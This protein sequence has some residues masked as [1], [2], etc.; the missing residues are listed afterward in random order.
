MKRNLQ[1]LLVILYL[2]I[3]AGNLKAN[4]TT[5]IHHFPYAGEVTDMLEDGNFLWLGT[6]DGLV[7]FNK[8]TEKAEFF[9][10]GQC[11]LLSLDITSLCK[12]S[13][14]NLWIRTLQGITKF[15]GEKWENYLNQNSSLPGGEGN[16]IT[17][18]KDGHIWIAD[19]YNLYDFYNGRAT[20]CNNDPP[21]PAN[22]YTRTMQT[23]GN[24]VLWLGS[25]TYGL[26][27]FEGKKWMR[28]DTSNSGIP[29]NMVNFIIIDRDGSKW[30]ATNKGIARL[31]DTIW[32]LWNTK[33]SSINQDSLFQ[34]TIDKHG[35]ICVQGSK[36]I[37]IFKDG[38]FT[39]LT[40]ETPDYSV[41]SM[42]RDSSDIFWMGTNYGLVK[43]D[44]KT[45]RT[46]KPSSIPDLAKNINA[47]A[48]DK[49]GTMW[50]GSQNKLIKYDGKNYQAFNYSNSIILSNENINSIQ[51]DSSGNIWILGYLAVYKYDGAN[52]NRF[53]TGNSLVSDGLKYMTVD[54]KGIVWLANGKSLLKYNGTGW[55]EFVP[56]KDFLKDDAFGDVAVDIDGSIWFIGWEG[57]IYK[58]K[59]SVWSLIEIKNYPDRMSYPLKLKI[60]AKGNKW[61]G[62]H[63]GLLKYDNEKLTF[64]T[65]PYD[66]SSR[67]DVLD[68]TFD[69]Q[70]N[71]WL[72]T[73]LGIAKIIDS[74][75]KLYGYIGLVY[76]WSSLIDCLAFDKGGN[77]W[78]SSRGHLNVIYNNYGDYP[79][80]F[81]KAVK[82]KYQLF[83]GKTFDYDGETDAFNGFEILPGENKRC[84]IRP[85]VTF[86]ND[87]KDQA[88]QFEVVATI[89]KDYENSLVFRKS[90][91][92]T[93]EALANP[94]SSGVQW[95]DEIGNPL[96][97][98]KDSTYKGLPPGGYARVSFDPFIPNEI[99]PIHH[100]RM[101][102]RA[103]SKNLSLP[104][105]TEFPYEDKLDDTLTRVV[106]SL[107]RI[108]SLHDECNEYVKSGSARLPSP[109]IWVNQGVEVVDGN[110]YCYQPM[111]AYQQ[112]GDF[113]HRSFT[114]KYA[115]VYLMNRKAGDAD[116][117]PG[118]RGG[119]TLTSHVI[120]M[121][122]RYYTTLSFTYQRTGKIGNFD[123]GWCDNSLVGPEHRVISPGD[124]LNAIR[125]PDELI[126]EYI[127]ENGTNIDRLL[128]PREEDWHILPRRGGAPPEKENPPLTI[129]GGG[130]RRVA[131]FEGDPDSILTRDNGLRA[132]V[133]D[134]GKDDYFKIA[135]IVIPDTVI[136]K[137]GFIRFRLRVNAE[138]NS[139]PGVLYDDS[140]NFYVDDI[141]ILFNCG[142]PDLSV[143]EIQLNTHYCINSLNTLNTITPYLTISNTHSNP[144][145]AFWVE[146]R[147]KLKNYPEWNDTTPFDQP[148]YYFSKQ[149][150][151]LLPFERRRI[152]LPFWNINGLS[153][154]LKP[155]KNVIQLWA[156]LV[157]PGGD[158]DQSNDTLYT[159][160]EIWFDKGMGY[161]NWENP[162]SD[163]GDFSYPGSGISLYGHS[164]GDDSVSNAVGDIGGSGPGQIAM[165]FEL[166]GKDTIF[167]FQAFFTQFATAPDPIRFAIY[168][169][170]DGKPGDLVEGSI[171]DRN[172]GFDDLRE[173]WYINEY[174]TYLYD[175]KNKPPVLEAGTY[176]AAIMQLGETG[177]Q[178]GA[179]GFRAGMVTT[180]YDSAGNGSRGTSLLIHKSLRK[181]DTASKHLLNDS[182]WYYENDIGSGNWVPFA[183]TVGNP[184]YSHLD[185]A[186]TIRNGSRSARTYSRGTFVPMLRVYMDGSHYKPSD[187]ENQVESSNEKIHA[188]PNPAVNFVV[189]DYVV[190]KPGLVDI[191]ISNMLGEDVKLLFNGYRAAG[192]YELPLSAKD[193][194]SG[195]YLLRLEQASGTATAKLM[196]VK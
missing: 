14:D 42:I 56:G 163:A 161:D 140:D 105:S 31:K 110:Q 2:A 64:F 36:G 195:M 183:P 166:P 84:G 6:L 8:L 142:C 130:G 5:Y 175:N 131:L 167:G 134:D 58:F 159:E 91:A 137:G 115:P 34:L 69:S 162:H 182:P 121:R 185:H 100:G 180:V 21:T 41:R 74:K 178:L 148:M 111:N 87:T 128:N 144:I 173:Q 19:D 50:M 196:I 55:D 95:V 83:N 151:Y 3:T 20:S 145:W 9:Y 75:V 30:L 122:Y 192:N 114:R 79:D 52:W 65:N 124:T 93:A 113:T 61:I 88:L 57:K 156:N 81:I 29:S 154:Y 67:F 22:L 177:L 90:K 86:K 107:N 76:R 47:I 13:S 118:V 12:D 48:F 141:R 53:D 174:S 96:Y 66:S 39:N 7:K 15:D 101:I 40:F 136:R 176:W 150:T 99:L 51:I 126:L 60:D 37:S 18:G 33:N 25:Y 4:D 116:V 127:I 38:T 59:D 191:T 108:E 77:L 10:P 32:T 171:L 170:L 135:Q 103:F 68:L 158:L 45:A 165:R 35:N 27:R 11:G 143:H 44:G 120:D 26:L 193:M 46:I 168:K 155:G 23:D 106:Y 49:E 80:N 117:P 187:V 147:M 186:G 24:G 63:W 82:M 139:T 160:Q 97:F 112:D 188:F 184:G 109:D 89:Y 92:V 190:E 179:Q 73:S 119:D 125:E 72:G 71:P 194:P 138:N 1:L 153:E 146:L 104:D 169:D 70:D 78:F 129:F 98:P 16:I 102:L 164:R 62:W 54:K 132:D 85:V 152:D 28:F 172:T 149:S 94:D 17:A 43:F 123:R 133:F 157:I 181:M 189:I